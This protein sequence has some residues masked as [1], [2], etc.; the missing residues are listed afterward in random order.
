VTHS[1]KAT[2][3][4]GQRGFSLVEVMVAMV[5]AVIA[6]MGLAQTFGTGR[7]LINRY[8]I[9]RD[10]LGAAQR[11]LEVLGAVSLAS[12]SLDAGT[13]TRLHGP[14]PVSLN[15]RKNGTVEWRSTWMDDPQDN[16]G[17][18]GDT[19]PHDYRKVTVVVRWNAAIPD[20]VPL[21]RYFVAPG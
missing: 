16:G 12:D 14:F 1:P 11:E 8:E 17:P 2:T 5:I 21:T 6:V 3:G 13:G 20:S 9:A 7:A 19:D 10:A 15:D 18:G 4:R